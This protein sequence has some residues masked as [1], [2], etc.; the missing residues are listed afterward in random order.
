[1]RSKFETF[2]GDNICVANVN[3]SLGDDVEEIL[4]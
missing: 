4:I 2:A 3:D 1:M